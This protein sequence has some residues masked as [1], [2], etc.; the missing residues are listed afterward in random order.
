MF[1]VHDCNLTRNRCK[2]KIANTY[3][4]HPGGLSQLWNGPLKIIPT[5]NEYYKMLTRLEVLERRVGIYTT[6]FTKK[7]KNMEEFK[8]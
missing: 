8:Y 3:L 4:N 5:I 2:Y 7:S 1:L 6:Q